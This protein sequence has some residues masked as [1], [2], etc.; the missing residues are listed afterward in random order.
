MHGLS[1]TLSLKPCM[2]RV[3]HKINKMQEIIIGLYT[4]SPNISYFLHA[5]RTSIYMINW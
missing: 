3:V 2:L 5:T 4:V 1:L